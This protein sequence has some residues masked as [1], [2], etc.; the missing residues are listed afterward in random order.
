MGSRKTVVMK[1]FLWAEIE[2][3][4]Y[5]MDLWTQKRKERVG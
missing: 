2:M 1:L 4:T 3:Q 5:R